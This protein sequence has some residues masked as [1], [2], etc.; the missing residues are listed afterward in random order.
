VKVRAEAIP[1]EEPLAGGVEGAAVVV[2]P[3][4]SGEALWPAS[5]FDY[6]GRGP[7]SR[8]RALG[9]GSS[10]DSWSVMPVPVYLV[11]HPGVG[12]VLID[13]GLHPSVAR[14]P[15][16]SFGRFLGRH[17]RVEEG[18]DVVSQLRARGVNPSDVAV[19][20]MTHLH[21]DHASAISEFPESL[22]VLSSSEWQAATTGS[23]PLLRGYVPSH[24][25][26]A[27][28]YNSIDFDGDLV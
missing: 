8:F 17:Y 3:I 5:F 19:V 4:S 12:P 6:Q 9:I 15:R 23:F 28:D 27:F 20:V 14:N 7:I 25:D 26:L 18:E 24:Y 2:E 16:D 10:P 1:L 22:F 13:A 11:R 21:N